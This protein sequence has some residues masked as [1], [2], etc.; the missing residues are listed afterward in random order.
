MIE[1]SRGLGLLQGRRAGWTWQ[2]LLLY[3][4]YRHQ[5]VFYLAQ[6]FSCNLRKAVRRL[7][8]AGPPPTQTTSYISGLAAALAKE[9][10]V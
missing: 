4:K 7:S 8:P 1:A 2:D 5:F 9:R 6:V 3:M 10:R